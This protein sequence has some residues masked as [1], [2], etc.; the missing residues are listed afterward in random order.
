[1][2]SLSGLSPFIFVFP[3]LPCRAF[4]F[5]LCAAPLEAGLRGGP[6]L[7]SEMQGSFAQEDT[8]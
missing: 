2:T 5:Q 3:A 7:Q 8:A 1:M 4:T 6:K